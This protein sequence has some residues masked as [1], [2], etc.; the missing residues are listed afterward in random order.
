MSKS[1]LEQI[2]K[3]VRR[4]VGSPSQNQLSESDLEDAIDTTYEQDLPAEVK[5]WNLNQT[6]EFYTVPYEDEYT[7]DT[8]TYYAV[9]APAYVDGYNAYFTQSRSEFFNRFPN[10][11]ILKTIQNGD[12]SA[13]VYSFTLDGV[14]VVKRAVTIQAIDSNGATQ[15]ATDVPDSPTSNTGTFLDA[16]TGLALTGTINYVTGAVT[17]TFTNTIPT[18]EEIKATTSQYTASK[19]SSILFFQNKLIVRPIPDNVYR[20]SVEVYSKPS[21]LLSSNNH[22]DSNTPDVTQWWQ[23]IAYGTAIKILGDRQDIESI[24]NIM[25]FYV[26]ERNKI[27]YRTATQLAQARTSTIYANQVESGFT[28]LSGGGFSGL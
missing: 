14:P 6:Y 20:I 28:P 23:F 15:V 24:D 16:K 17:I 18:T 13:G 5:L 8:D 27:V 19:P 4:L 2:K 21:Q 9:L 11:Q 10:T 12:G 7:L 3:K 25:P 1:T 26:N 22:A